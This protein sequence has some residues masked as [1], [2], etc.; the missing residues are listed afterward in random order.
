M[1][2]AH[3]NYFIYICEQY[4]LMS[5]QYQVAL[6]TWL[7]KATCQRGSENMSSPFP[8]PATHYCSQGLKPTTLQNWIVSIR[9]GEESPNGTSN[10]GLS[11][12]VVTNLWI[13][14]LKAALLASAFSCLARCQT[15][16]SVCTG[17]FYSQP[18]WALFKL[19]SDC[20]STSLFLRTLWKTWVV[21]KDW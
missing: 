16:A 6:V 12:M 1:V 20:L 5:W 14:R 7:S 8:C 19:L 13:Q 21:P 18:T 10:R 4:L 9:E 3:K 17:G 11:G 15:A 2:S